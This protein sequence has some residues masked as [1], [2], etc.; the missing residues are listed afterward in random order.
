MKLNKN[1]VRYLFY[2]LLMIFI[3]PQV[4]AYG[5]TGVSPLDK[6]IE[7]I[8][9]VF[10]IQI[11]RTNESVQTGFMMFMIF[12]VL[13][14]VS[15]MALKRVKFFDKK[16]AGIVSFA[17][18]AIGVFMMPKEWL[19]ATGGLI[20]ALMSSVIFLM[21]FIGLSVVAVFTLRPKGDDDKMG[22]LKNLLGLI[23]LLLLLFLLDE[24]AAFVQLPTAMAVLVSQKWLKKLF[25]Y[26]PREKH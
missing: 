13:F 20:T 22:W 11:L 25:R 9:N 7:A 1:T 3:A 19:M 26:K 24:W 8:S 17:F 12:I 21:V 14:A 10:N 16:T 4:F 18:S 5:R 15:N 23:L 6:G 2:S